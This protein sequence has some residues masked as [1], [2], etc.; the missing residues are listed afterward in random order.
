M[1][2]TISVSEMSYYLILQT[3]QY[4]FIEHLILHLNKDQRIT[5]YTCNL[6][7]IET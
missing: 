4:V 7:F 3:P 6:S 2:S 5:V 1:A